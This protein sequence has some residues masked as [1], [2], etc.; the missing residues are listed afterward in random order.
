MLFKKLRLYF[1]IDNLI[2][3]DLLFMGW[4][5]CLYFLGWMIVISWV[6]INMVSKIVRIIIIIVVVKLLYVLYCL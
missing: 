6:E 2:D 3:N 5:C 1:L 4:L